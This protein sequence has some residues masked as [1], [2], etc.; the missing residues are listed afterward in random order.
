MKNLIFLLL[1]LTVVNGLYAQTIQS[2]NHATTGYI[3]PDGTI[4]DSN[5]STVGYII[6]PPSESIQ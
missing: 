6:S 5:H 4:Q 1:M 3:K 2:K